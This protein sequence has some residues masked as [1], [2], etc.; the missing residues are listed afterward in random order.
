MSVTTFGTHKGH[1]IRRAEIRSGAG[2][3]AAAIEW[4][5]I[6]QDLVLEV[7]GRPRRLVLGFESMEAYIAGGAHIGATAGR[8]A[9]RIRNARFMLEGEEIRLDQNVPGGHHIHGGSDGYGKRPWTIEDASEASVTLMTHT[10]HGHMGYPG[11]CT[12]RLTYTVEGTTLRVEMTA[13]VDRPTIV[14]MAH[15]SYFNLLDEGAGDVL[16]HTLV[17]N[18]GRYTP[19]DEI[20]IP[21]GEILPVEGTV[22]DFRETRPIRHPGA[23]PAGAGAGAEA[24]TGDEPFRYDVNFEIDRT[25][26]PEDGLVHCA[27][28]AAPDGSVAMAVYTTEPGIQFYDGR[29]LAPAMPGHGGISYGPSSGLCLEAQKFADAPNNPA[30]PSAV[31]TPETGYRQVTEYRFGEG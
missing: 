24:G 11:A 12:A 21:T 3:M 17:V 29:K 27:T 9:N 23:E 18:G 4:G 7:G 26:A 13:E 20:F 28:A 15:H 10:P 16:D 1:T 25:G 14:N 30:F 6:L 2:L 5:G 8:C 22:F 19:L 31:V